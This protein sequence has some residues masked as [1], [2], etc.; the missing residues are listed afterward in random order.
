MFQKRDDSGYKP[1]IPGIEMKALVYGEKTLMTKF[2]L[3]K[4]SAIPPHAHPHEQ[5][6]HLVKGRLKFTIGAEEHD[7][8]EG[9][10]WCIAG[11]VE[12]KVDVLEDAVVLEVFSPVREEYLPAERSDT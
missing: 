7:A 1:A 8:R 12:H 2:L 6:G 11:N 3:K 9:D 5:T 4:G 10:S